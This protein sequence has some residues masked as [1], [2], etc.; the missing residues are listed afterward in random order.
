[1]STSVADIFNY[2]QAAP[3][4]ATSG[5][6]RED[7]L[8][9]IANAGYEVIVNLALHDDPRYSLVDEGSSVKALGL[10]YIHIPVQFNAPSESDLAEFFEAMK[11]CTGVGYGCIAPQTC[12][13]RRFSASTGASTRVGPKIARLPCYAKFGSLTPCGLSS[14]AHSCSK[15]MPLNR[16][17]NAY[18][19]RRVIGRAWRPVTLVR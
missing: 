4:L 15:Q 7:Q 11:R 3:D 8:R 2:R 14:S 12:G 16:L 19:R 13:S 6:P 1:M 5:Q 18:R 17:V 10:Q 9:A